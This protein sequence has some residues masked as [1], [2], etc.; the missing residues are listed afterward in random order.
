M[1]TLSHFG[2]LDELI[3]VVYQG[4]ERFIVLSAVDSSSWTVYVGLKGP[5]GRWWRGSWSAHDVTL[6][7]GSKSSSQILQ[8][9]AHN[10]S[11]AFV[12]GELCVG[13]W[14]PDEGAKINFTLGPTSKKPVHIPLVELSAKEAASHATNI[15]SAIAIQAQSRKCQLY[16]P[17]FSAQIAVAAGPSLTR[18]V[19]HV[20]SPPKKAQASVPAAPPQAEDETE[21]AQQKIKSLE[22]ELA[23]VK[24][25]KKAKSKSPSSEAEPKP[26][27]TTRRPKGASLA[28][29]H[30]KARKYQ[31]VEFESDDD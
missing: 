20:H 26:S 7:I 28:N 3:Q 12:N 25:A 27:A 9:F 8:S 10:L 30:K 29:P 23:H 11:E 15:L 1:D 22:A 31:A 21:A 13:D 5:E 2:A 19:T 16:P 4:F 17:S 6:F 24:A 14:A 18:S